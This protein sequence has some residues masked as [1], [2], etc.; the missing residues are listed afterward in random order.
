MGDVMK[1]IVLYSEDRQKALEIKRLFEDKFETVFELRDIDSSEDFIG[2]ADYAAVEWNLRIPLIKVLQKTEKDIGVAFYNE[3]FVSDIDD[4]TAIDQ[5]LNDAVNSRNWAL[6]KSINLFYLTGDIIRKRN[7][8]KSKPVKLQIET[9]DLCNAK[10]IMCSHAYSEGTGIDILQSGILDKLK[11][12]LPFVKVIVLHGNGEPFL[13]KDITKYLGELSEYGIQFIANTNL[14]ILTDELL[15]FLNTG[16]IELNISCDGHTKELYESI[17]K[18]LSYERFVKNIEIVRKKCPNLT[19]KMAVV[20][21]RQN[22]KSLPEIVDFAGEMGFDEI[23]LN[24]LCVDEKNGNLQDAAY[25]YA[26]DLVKHTSMAL[27]KGK[28]KNIKVTVPYAL[29]PTEE[30]KREEIGEEALNI[31]GSDS[32]T[33][34]P[35]LGVCDWVVECPYIDLRGNVAPCCIKQKENFGNLHDLDFESVWNGEPYVSFRS[36]FQKGSLPFICKGCD[37]VNQKRLEY[38]S[39]EN[40]GLKTLEKEKRC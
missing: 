30:I 7:V 8:L 6:C 14:S 13:K 10:C 28:K 20:V 32:S 23:I 17:R 24:Q 33:N 11:N 34:I 35:C 38:L 37:F 16:F 36:E 22:M 29:N 2:T 18:G 26:E 1:G 40:I 25:L 12:I 9:T 39:I 27:E 5:V 3:A 31:E 15:E 21:M 4:T 19:M